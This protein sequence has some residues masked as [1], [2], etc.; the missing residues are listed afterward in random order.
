M[1]SSVIVTSSARSRLEAEPARDAVRLNGPGLIQ[2]PDRQPRITDPP[3]ALCQLEDR[4]GLPSRRDGQ[5]QPGLVGQLAEDRAQLPRGVAREVDDS[6]ETGRQLRIAVQ[7][8]QQG[9]FSPVKITAIWA[10]CSSRYS[11]SCM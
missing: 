9:V 11:V 4:C 6:Q 3:A 1:S 7:P 2:Q 5:P 8:F 10:A